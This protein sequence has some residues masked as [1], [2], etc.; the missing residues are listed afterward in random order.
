MKKY[1]DV[2]NEAA[3]T[4]GPKEVNT[5]VNMLLKAFSSRGLIAKT[6]DKKDL[7]VLED[8]MFK[9]ENKWLDVQEDNDWLGQDGGD[10]WRNGIK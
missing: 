7:K 1:K 10:I 6:A 4:T 9:V 2:I 5:A 3:I 8:L